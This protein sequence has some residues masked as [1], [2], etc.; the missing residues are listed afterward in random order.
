MNKFDK[1]YK[2]IMEDLESINQYEQQFETNREEEKEIGIYELEHYTI[3]FLEYT[4]PTGEKYYQYL[5]YQDND[6]KALNFGSDQFSTTDKNELVENAIEWLFDWSDYINEIYD[7]N[8]VI[9]EAK[10]AIQ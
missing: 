1:T 3:Y 6:K 7:I 8:E 9:E 2:L 4:K 10:Q 5:V